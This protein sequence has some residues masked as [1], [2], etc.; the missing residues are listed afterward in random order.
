M[1][2]KKPKNSNYCA[3]IVKVANTVTLENCDNVCHSI[4]LSNKVITSKEVKSGDIGL[5]F[6]LETKLSHEFLSNNNLYRHK[7]L[8]IDKEKAGYFEDNGRI[9]CVKF[10]GNSSEG[11]FIPLSSLAFTNHNESL[12]VGDEFDE[13]N[14]IKIC[15]K[16][17]VVNKQTQ[18]KSNNN[19]ANK[20]LKRF[21][22]LIAN[23]FRFHVDT[24]QLYKNI[25]RIK[26]D[27]LISITSKLHGCS[28]GSHFIL[29]KRNLNFIEKL[30]LKIIPK[31]QEIEY[32]YI[33]NSRKVIKNQY[34]NP[35]V[36]H[37]YN[38]D[39]WSKAHDI[40]KPYLIKGMSIYYEIVGYV[41]KG[42]YIQK[43][44]DYGCKDGK[45]SI[46][47]YRITSTNEDGKV[48]EWSMWQL[49]EWC[50]LNG[51]NPVPLLYYGY[52]KDLFPKLKKDEHWN[53]NFLEKLKEKYLEKDCEICDNKVPGE[54]VVIRVECNDIEA[55]KLK[56][57]RFYAF[58][59]K[60][61][62]KGEIDIESIE[63]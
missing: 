10:R 4:I 26:P 15:E 16:Y 53:E 20:K 49:Q 2:L 51:L 14:G 17:I 13:I 1:S 62:D 34:I 5:Y 58:E 59:T 21:N 42:N 40:L 52:A 30:L 48:H 6:P 23:Q 60:Q 36:T 28:G 54:G 31:I 55:Y 27:S 32:N 38:V 45:F 47:I 11:F 44:Y 35:N 12:K 39:I 57:E 29:C 37:Y 56:S 43:P 19:K 50:K 7:E 22:K 25:H 41:D 8:N 18:G 61:L 63:N 3:N 9:R 33:Y 24:G 46:Y